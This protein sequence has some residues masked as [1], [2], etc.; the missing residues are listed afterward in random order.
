MTWL[1]FCSYYI[2]FFQKRYKKW[3]YSQKLAHVNLDIGTI[4]LGILKIY[5]NAC[6]I[7]VAPFHDVLNLT[8]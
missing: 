7:G 4:S 3:F 1:S 6:Y 2:F 5:L 8:G